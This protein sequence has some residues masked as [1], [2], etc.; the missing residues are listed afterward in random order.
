MLGILQRYTLREII[1]PTLMG[2]VVFTFLLLVRMIFRMMDLLV[3]TEITLADTVEMILCILP[4]LFPL[5]IPMA[6]LLG[7]LL[8]IGR[9]ASDNEI[10]AIRTSGVHLWRICWPIIVL[11]ALVS[12]AMVWM[13]LSLAPSLALRVADLELRI[14]FKM[15]NAF[16]AGR[17][18]EDLVQ[19]RNGT[20]GAIM[21]RERDDET[22]DLRNIILALSGKAP[23]PVP[24]PLPGTAPR[25]E[26]AQ[27]AGSDL[28]I[29][30]PRG[31]LTADDNT[32]SIQVELLDGTIHFLDRDPARQGEYTVGTFERLTRSGQVD[33]GQRNSDGVFLKR[34]R[35]MTVSELRHELALIRLNH[36]WNRR[37]RVAEY[38][39]RL[40]DARQWERQEDIPALEAELARREAILRKADGDV[41]VPTI[42][43]IQA[44][45]DSGEGGV[46]RDVKYDWLYVSELAKRFSLPLACISV[47]L[48]AIPLAIFIKPSAK[49]LGFAV[50]LALIF[51][52]YILLE[53]GAKMALSGH[54]WG[55]PLTFL[56]NLLLGGI[57]VVFMRRTLQ[58]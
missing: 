20:D 26:P 4:T 16:N 3:N 5:T 43:E 38:R 34:P 31:R 58:Q 57:G 54:P 11:S 9:M 49:T 28:V 41:E 45:F 10:I 8:G 50:A 53:W 25:E 33:I 18:Y 55:V 30:A 44:I 15:E 19:D 48:L 40:A 12:G 52:Y 42:E 46:Y 56:P 17:V 13:N 21:F 39:A 35:M 47:I 37:L 29:T 6:L 22:G 51:I 36:Y 2:L 32:A 23:E 7:V 1:G 24:T 27:L 14:R